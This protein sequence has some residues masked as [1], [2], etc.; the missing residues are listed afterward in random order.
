MNNLNLDQ[1]HSRKLLCTFMANQQFIYTVLIFLNKIL[2]VDFCSKKSY[3]IHRYFWNL[4]YNISKLITAKVNN[5]SFNLGYSR[6]LPL[7]SMV[8]Q[9]L[10]FIVFLSLNNIL[11]VFV[12]YFCAKKRSHIHSY[13]WISIFR[14]FKETVNLSLW[15]V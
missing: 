14:C 11:I 8:K 12:M 13:F 3:Y 7:A 4:R 6:K 9:N 15:L 2:I 1:E 10:I 5:Q